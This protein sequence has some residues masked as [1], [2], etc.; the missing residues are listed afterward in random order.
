[1]VS[2][3]VERL[4]IPEG[5]VVESVVPRVIGT[6]IVFTLSSI[7]ENGE[8]DRTLFVADTAGQRSASPVKGLDGAVLRA[9][10]AAAV[11]GAEKVVVWVDDVDVVQVDLLTGLALPVVTQAQEYWGVSSDGDQI[12]VVDVGGT[13]AVDIDTLEEVRFPA[14]ELGGR[15][16]F[17]GQTHVMATGVR[18]QTVA[19]AT[20]QGTD[21]V[22]LVVRDDGQGSLEPLYRTPGDLGSIGRFVV[23]PGDQY[24]AIEVIPDRSQVRPDGRLLEPRAESITTV[25]IEVESGSVVRSVEG[26]WPV[27]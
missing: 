10:K 7:A 19:V 9:T 15:P 2:G 16:V 4:V 13:V 18:L 1:V 24:V 17:E 25:V 27:W 14:A 21:F 8:Y 3:L 23:S 22:S 12:V 26:F 11:P 6:K 20:N 5:T